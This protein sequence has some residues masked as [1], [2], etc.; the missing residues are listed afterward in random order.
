M[1]HTLAG[2]CIPGYQAIT[3]SYDVAFPAASDVTRCGTGYYYKN[4]SCVAYEQSVCESGYVYENPAIINSSFETTYIGGCIGG[5][6]PILAHHDAM[7]VMVSAHDK[8]GAGEYPT[9][10]GCAPHPTTGCPSN[11]YAITPATAFA[12]IEPDAECGTN[13]SA[14]YDTD[15]CRKYLG[16]AMAQVCTPQ[17]ECL[18]AGSTLR[19]ST[20]I[21]LPLYREKLTTPALNIGFSNGDVCYAN[22]APNAAAGTINI[23]YN[24]EVYHVGE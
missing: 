1:K 18:S 10:T 14:Y 20:G 13:Y 12:R 19:T 22:M 6:D 8:C 2:K 11:Y 9:G 21:V 16:A 4:G 5:Y 15:I 7:Y 23:M 3:I 24:Q 17:Y